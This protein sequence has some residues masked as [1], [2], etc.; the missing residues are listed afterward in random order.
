VRLVEARWARVPADGGAEL[1]VALHTD[2]TDRR[3]RDAEASRAERW[4]VARALATAFADDAGATGDF[5]RRFARGADPAANV[6]HRGA[7]DGV[8]VVGPRPL[9]RELVRA[10]LDAAG[11]EPVAA[12]D[13]FQAARLLARHRDGF[14]AAV[15]AFEP[16]AIGVAAD[17]RRFHPILPLVVLDDPATTSADAVLEAVAEAVAESRWTEAGL[18][19]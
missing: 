16:D 19:T 17:L 15:L 1:V 14:R 18:L 5:V 11:Y 3:R 10:V 7:G 4:D 13:R 6:L 12:A 9:A 2:V 8:L